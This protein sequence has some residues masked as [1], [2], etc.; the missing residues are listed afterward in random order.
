MDDGVHSRLRC[1]RGEIGGKEAQPLGL[2]STA[3]ASLQ[4]KWTFKSYENIEAFLNAIGKYVKLLKHT[5]ACII[6]F[7]SDVRSCTNA[8]LNSLS[9]NGLE[10]SYL[11][12]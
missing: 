5:Y 10:A 12:K 3:M 1:Q 2:R 4:G 7:D 6:L 9:L 11:N 8:G